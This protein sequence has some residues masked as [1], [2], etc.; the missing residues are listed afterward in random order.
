MKIRARDSGPTPHISSE[1]DLTITITRNK[2]APVFTNDEFEFNIDEIEEVGASIM[3][4]SARDRDR[5]VSI[6]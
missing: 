1:V 5:N 4:A 2:E 3:K 6:I